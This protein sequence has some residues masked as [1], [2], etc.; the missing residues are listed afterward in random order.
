MRAFVLSIGLVLAGLLAAAA[1]ASA[2]SCATPSGPRFA[3]GDIALEGVALAGGQ[4]SRDLVSPARVLVTRYLKGDGPAVAL[5]TTG[6]FEGG[7]IGGAFS[8]SAGDTVRVVGDRSGDGRGDFLSGRVPPGTIVT[9]FCDPDT[10]VMR[11]ARGH[12][13][14]GDDRVLLLARR[15]GALLA[16]AGG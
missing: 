9:R 11:R 13:T 14:A 7:S 15:S 16:F 8:P 6:T 12:H 2:L 3:S 4:P 10:L 5:V 1:P